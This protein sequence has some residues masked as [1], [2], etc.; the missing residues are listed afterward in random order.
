MFVHFPDLD[1]V[2][3]A[4]GWGSP[5]QVAVA[6]RTDQGVGIIMAAIK[7]LDL[8]EKTLVIVTADQGGSG[9]SHGA[10][11]SF[12]HYI[13]WI[14]VGPGVR[15][16]YDLTLAPEL[17]V[18]VEDVFA[19]ALQF[20]GITISA[21]VDGKPVLAIFN[22]LEQ[23]A[24]AQKSRIN[25]T[26]SIYIILKFFG[27]AGGG[28]VGYIPA[29]IVLPKY[30]H[31]YL[32]SVCGVPLREVPVANPLALTAAMSNLMRASFCHG[33]SAVPVVVLYPVSPH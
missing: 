6:E 3:H 29:G 1:A 23:V 24:P 8:R 10:K 20:L 27:A 30:S 19:T 31:I 2:G 28:V 17:A 15:E 21:E 4:L 12:S 9:R 16:N 14:A 33:H 11:T 26:T 18:H 32:V 22:K 7:E 25:N 5:E 13:P